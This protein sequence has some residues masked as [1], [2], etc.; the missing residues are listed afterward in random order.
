MNTPPFVAIFGPLG[1]AQLA[2][3]RS[4]KRAGVPTC[5]IHIVSREDR[6]FVAT[7]ATHYLPVESDALE[8]NETKQR[9]TAELNRL[10]VKGAAAV[11]YSNS[12][13]MD[14]LK[15]QHGL[16]ATIYGIGEGQ[17]GF[18][19]SKLAQ[20]DCASAVGLKCL[21]TSVVRPECNDPDPLL[22]FPLVARPDNPNHFKPNF[23]ME[24]LHGPRDLEVLLGRF[25][26]RQGK[27]VLQRFENLPNLIVHGFRSPD[28]RQGPMATFLVQH[29]FEGVSLAIKP[30]ST[31]GR[32]EEK[33][34]LFCDRA[35][36]VGPYHF[37]FLFDKKI[38]DFFFLD[39]NGRL[40]G[41]TA[42]VYTLGYNEPLSVLEAFGHIPVGSVK[43]ENQLAG[44]GCAT[45]HV[46]LVK[47]IKRKLVGRFSKIDYL[48]HDGMRAI[49]NLAYGFATWKDE[50]IDWR[51]PCGTIAYFYQSLI[52][53]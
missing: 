44:T 51:D 26:E 33:C 30:W 8:S 25:L 6:H 18:M 45:S 20:N 46:A 4:W 23:K 10:G 36:I 29:K 9:I 27:I 43:Y 16:D 28:G 12:L 19:N 24:L 48:P 34:R 2:V 47:A 42:K 15:R 50:V 3:L 5:F 13:Y 31:N 37:E 49:F 38:E 53:N 17:I 11:G 21:P 39:F 40:G 52:G 22:A 35:G 7:L 41:T 14:H 1:P 32:I